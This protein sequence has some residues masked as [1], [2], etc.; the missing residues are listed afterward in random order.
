MQLLL[1]IVVVILVVF[2]VITFQNPDVNVTMKFI[3]WTFESKPLALV[4]AVPFAVG[5]LAGSFIFV[6]PWLKKASLAR[7][8]KKRIHELE[9]ELAELNAAASPELVEAEVIGE[10]EEIKEEV[11]EEA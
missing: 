5:I 3:K 8:Q 4:L 1:F 10:G 11:K 2:G 9:S 6:P 7:H